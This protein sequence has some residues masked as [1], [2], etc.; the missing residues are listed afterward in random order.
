MFV[1]PVLVITKVAVPA[2]EVQTPLM[3]KLAGGGGGGGGTQ[4]DISATAVNEAS[5]GVENV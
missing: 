1:V 2:V 5:F 3:D 4:V